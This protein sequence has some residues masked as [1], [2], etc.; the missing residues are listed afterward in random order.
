MVILPLDL[1]SRFWGDLS[2]A[3]SLGGKSH[4]RSR[5]WRARL[6]APSLKDPLGAEP[7]AVSTAQGIGTCTKRRSRKSAL[8][9]SLAAQQ[10]PPTVNDC[11]ISQRQATHIEP[12]HMALQETSARKRAVGLWREP[13]VPTQ[14]APSFLTLPHTIE[15]RGA[16]YA[17]AHAR[18]DYAPP[19]HAQSHA[20]TY[21][22]FRCKSR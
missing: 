2:C 21:I 10:G 3:S 16:V 17:R 18:K 20:T 15:A 4:G 7:F 22:R 8:V 14:V 9:H 1:T 5:R 12:R 6:R 19:M 11:L 13:M